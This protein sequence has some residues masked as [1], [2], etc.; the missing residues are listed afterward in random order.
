[1]KLKAL[2]LKNYRRFAELAIDFDPQ[3]TVIVAR[4][5][6]GKTTVLEAIAAALGPFVGAFDY[7][8]AKHIERSDARYARIKN[9]EENEQ[10]FPV[11]VRASLQEPD[12]QWERALNG[13][14]SRTTTKEAAPLGQYGKKLKDDLKNAKETLLPIMRYYSSKRLWVNIKN[15]STKATLTESRQAAYEDCLSASS[16]YTQL[17]QW[18]RKASYALVQQ[19]N[20]PG[21]EQSN[22]QFRMQ[23]IQGAVGSVLKQEDW[24]DFHYSFVFDELAMAHCLSVCLAMACVP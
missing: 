9:G 23:G 21:Y 13:A 10:H 8:K 20:L 6:K 12:L 22:L 17:Q 11:I 14:K 5:G 2:Y 15:T 3:L 7:G 1:M 4:N 24:T 16:T 19:K 18:M